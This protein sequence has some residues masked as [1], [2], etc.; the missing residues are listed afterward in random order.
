MDE[1]EAVRIEIRLPLEH[2]LAGSIHIRLVLLG[3]LAGIFSR[4]ALALEETR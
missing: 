2:G 4:E 1:H 3:G